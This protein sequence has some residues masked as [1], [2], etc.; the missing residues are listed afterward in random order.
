MELC[1]EIFD[2]NKLNSQLYLKPY[3][4]VST[5]SDTGIVEVLPDTMSLDAL[6]KTQGFESLPKYFE[7]VIF[8]EQYH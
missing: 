4:I 5:G 3:R 7:K 2:D 8:T 1:K 6:K